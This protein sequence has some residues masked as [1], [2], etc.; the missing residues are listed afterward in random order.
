VS[1]K[2]AIALY[3]E[4]R[5]GRHALEVVGLVNAMAEHGHVEDAIQYLA[6]PL[7]GD[8]FPLHFI[9]NLARECHDDETRLRL[10]TL[11]ARAWKEYACGDAD[12]TEHFAGP[13]F[14]AFFGRQWSLLPPEEARPILKDLLHWVL[15][16][17]AEPGQYPLT[18]NSEDPELASQNEHHLFEL[19]PALQALEP[20]AAGG[21]LEDHPQL[22]IAW[23]RFPKG[24]QSV[25]EE[26]PKFNR[27]TDDSML[28]GDW[29]VM[30]MTE[31]LASDFDAAFREAYKKYARDSDS[32]DPN[33]APKE[34]WP[35]AQEFRNILFKAGQHQ[36]LAA[37]KH[38]DRIP[39]PDL[40]LFAQI[41][42]CAGA[43][44]LPQIGGCIVTHRS[45]AESCRVASPAELD[46]IFGPVM[47]GIRCPKCEWAPRSKNLWSC[48]CGHHWSTFDTRGLC[49]ECGYQW[50]ETACPQCSEMS[51]HADWY[52]HHKNE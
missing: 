35:S 20:E 52:A 26:V 43:E 47:P 16:E 50:E 36:G 45:D 18:G 34:C 9:N 28:I 41:E 10:L 38:L 22:A 1:P 3:T 37:E 13:A 7:P 44:G 30:P 19:L 31:A 29:E 2:H 40:R 32:E 8:H 27:A 14:N 11:A 25:W 23:K 5:S 46:E 51:P 48:K 4:R 49:P 39:D 6:D 17:K 24:M 12:R 42:L 33:E 15:E 21:V